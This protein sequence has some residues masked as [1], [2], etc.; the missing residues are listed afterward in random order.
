[1]LPLVNAD[2]FIVCNFEKID[3]SC[4]TTRLTR[5]RN[6]FLVI[7]RRVFGM[8]KREKNCHLNALPSGSQSP[9]PLNVPAERA[10]AEMFTG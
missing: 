9:L 7:E 10:C 4:V 5:Q 6:S 1:M 8:S 3:F 2:N